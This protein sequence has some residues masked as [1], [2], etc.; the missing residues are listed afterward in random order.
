MTPPEPEVQQ[1]SA[2][3]RPYQPSYFLP[4]KVEGRAALF[5]F[6]T[7]CNTNLLAK[8][9]FDL[10]PARLR[11]FL[12]PC[13]SHGVMADG[14]RLPFYGI[15]TLSGRLRDIKFEETF[16]V[17]QINEDAIFGMPFLTSHG[18]VMEFGQPTIRING[19]EL[20]CTDRYGRPLMST[21]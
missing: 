19:K 14:T 2:T 5:L 20:L 18:C 21:V 15:I 16:V 17:S 13:H 7:G 10:L 9:V 12:E 8:H 3:E 11:Q 4:G 1:T 6:D